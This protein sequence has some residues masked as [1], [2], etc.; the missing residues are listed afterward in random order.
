MPL[1]RI[2]VI[3]GRTE[4]ELQLLADA[5]HDAV[6][7]SF[8]VPENDRYQTINQHKPY[9][10]YIEDTGLGFGRTNNIVVIQVISKTRTAEQKK[11]L[12]KNVAG[13]LQSRCHINS[14]DVM[15]SITDN[16]EADWSFGMGEAQFL[17]GKL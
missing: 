17:N 6:V 7:E 4:E 8:E 1:I 3:E 14:E 2:D 15:I 5:V 13:H 12:Y 10:M 11:R 16:T 9:E